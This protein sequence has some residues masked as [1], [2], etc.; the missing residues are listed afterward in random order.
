M[1]LLDLFF[2]DNLDFSVKFW[3]FLAEIP[4]GPE[5]DLGRS[6]GIISSPKFQ[7]PTMLANHFHVF[8]LKGPT[9]HENR[10]FRASLKP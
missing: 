8:F 2:R 9:Q 3:V 7:H 1:I 6:F 10:T 4:R 5:D